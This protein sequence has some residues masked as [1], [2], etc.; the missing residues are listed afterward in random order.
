MNSARS[1]IPTEVLVS[2][3]PHW[4]YVIDE[5][6]HDVPLTQ[7]DQLNSLGEAPIHIAA[8]KGS[9]TDL[10]WLLDNGADS[11]QRGAHQMTPL[12]YAYVGGKQENIAALLEAG[13]DRAARTEMGLLPAEG[14]TAEGLRA[15]MGRF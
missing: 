15:E 4:W 14:A 7:L 9:V 13:A 11:E 12:H 5:Q 10:R 8:W 1:N 3:E 6:G 2:L